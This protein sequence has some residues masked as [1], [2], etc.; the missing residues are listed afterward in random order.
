MGNIRKNLI[1]LQNRISR[2]A[3][4]TGRD[5]E[6]ILLLAVTKNRDNELI[7]EAINSGLR[8]LGENRIQEALPKIRHFKGQGI[9]WHLSGI[10]REIRQKKR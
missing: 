5:P 7:R 6:E 8:V 10:F 9:E 1:E 2:A 4:K 3:R